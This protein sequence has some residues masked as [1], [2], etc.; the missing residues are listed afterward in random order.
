MIPLLINVEVTGK[1]PEKAELSMR[2]GDTLARGKGSDEALSEAP[3]SPSPGHKGT[4][5]ISGKEPRGLFEGRCRAG[6]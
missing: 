4:L 5:R 6:G 2:A 1:G 3:L